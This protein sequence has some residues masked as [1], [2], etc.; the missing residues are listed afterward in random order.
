MESCKTKFGNPTL[1]KSP[2]KA[3]Q[4]SSSFSVSILLTL[5]SSSFLS[6]IEDGGMSTKGTFSLHI[7]FGL[8]KK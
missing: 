6:S 5:R 8:N 2:Y 7:Y 3:I 1:C 4:K